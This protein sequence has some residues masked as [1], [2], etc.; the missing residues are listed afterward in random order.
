MVV[1][2][3][4]WLRL[5][6]S[7]PPSLRIYYSLIIDPAA[8]QVTVVAR[9]PTLSSPGQWST[10]KSGNDKNSLQKQSDES[11]SW[12]TV[13][14]DAMRKISLRP[15]RQARDHGTSRLASFIST[16]VLS[17]FGMPFDI[18]MQSM[19][20]A[21]RLGD[22]TGGVRFGIIRSK[23]LHRPWMSVIE[24]CNFRRGSFYCAK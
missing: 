9:M 24:N 13:I 14:V 2:I 21:D 10:S 3:Q 15:H 23:L 18:L 6:A 1:A 4:I 16:G 12:P 17:S 7:I 22:I 19:S 5:R 20:Q 11:V 8:G